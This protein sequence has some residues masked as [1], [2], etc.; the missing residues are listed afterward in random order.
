[1]VQKKWMFLIAILL[2]VLN[3]NVLEAK[4]EK[5]VLSAPLYGKAINVIGDSYMKNHRCPYEETWH[6][7]V[8]EKYKMNYRNYSRN[9]RCLVFSF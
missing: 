5:N 8:A 2:L 1:M 9:G 6:Y 4:G 7:L 3:C